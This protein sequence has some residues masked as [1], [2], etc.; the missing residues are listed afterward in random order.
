[1][2]HVDEKARHH[3]YCAKGVNETWLELPNAEHALASV[4]GQGPALDFLTARFN[5]LSLP[6]VSNC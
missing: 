2:T 3:L 4:Q 6:P 5:V 1:M